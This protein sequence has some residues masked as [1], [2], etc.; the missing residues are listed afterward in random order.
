MKSSFIDFLM[1]P[2]IGTNVDLNHLR[3]GKLVKIL[4]RIHDLGASDADI[5]IGFQPTRT[6]DHHMTEGISETICEYIIYKK[7]LLPQSYLKVVEVMKKSKKSEFI[8]DHRTYDEE[9]AELTI[10]KWM[11]EI[12]EN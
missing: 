8:I 11:L 5:H 9:E 12:I 1:S 4:M 7:A 3:N 10:L 2:Y 6:Y